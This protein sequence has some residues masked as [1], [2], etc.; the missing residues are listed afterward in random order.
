MG[1]LKVAA[2]AISFCLAASIVFDNMKTAQRISFMDAESIQ[3]R[4]ESQWLAQRTSMKIAG[5]LT[6]L[7]TM[8][9]IALAG[10][11]LERLAD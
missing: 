8:A 1:K 3:S 4:M 9:T 5:I 7:G 11:R 2:F 6:S 10:R